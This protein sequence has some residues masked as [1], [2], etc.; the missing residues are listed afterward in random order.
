MR[1]TQNYWE[2][3]IGQISA[4]SFAK[5][6]NSLGPG[7]VYVLTVMGAGDIVSNSA[8]GA[9]YQYALI[10]ALGVTLI[11]R[12]IWVGASAKY[13]LVTGETLL[14]GYG[15]L[16][17]WLIWTVLAALFVFRHFYNLYLIVLLGTTWDLLFHLPTH[18][19]SAI[20]SV[21]FSVAGFVMM[22]WGG[23]P[24][25]E[26]FCKALVAAK[27][28]SL[29]IAAALSHPDPAG[30]LKGTFVPTIPGAT[31]FYSSILVLM[32]L[33]G[34]EAGSM[35]N[36]TYPYFMYEKGWR[37]VSYIRQQRFDL[38]FGVACI[39]V[40]GALL[41]IAAAGT[42]HPLGVKLE[43]PEQLVRIFSQSQG[44]VGLL[45]FALGL[46]GAA[47][48]TYVAAT[49][50]YALIMTDL[51]RSYIPRLRKKKVEGENKRAT[52]KN[53][54][55]Y[56]WSIAFWAFSPLYILFVHARPVWFV[57]MVSS[58]VVVVIPAL[59]LPLLRLTND[60]KLM[61]KHTNGWFTNMVL[62][63]LIV[64]SFYFTYQNI[65]SV[66]QQLRPTFH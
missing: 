16:G 56:R 64:V 33:I 18:W 42:I 45:I 59:A 10:W 40:M 57:L 22:S 51:C 61:G 44:L 28:I 1:L 30:I 5:R 32:A 43:G 36:L 21:F 37:D 46:W 17:N 6:L 27:G 49:T 65:L 53:D 11:F 25:L 4:S 24:I 52:A 23:Y 31:G 12:Y 13:V 8:A 15:R 29:I 39:F 9:D 38:G 47:F 48:S 34:T 35:T 50:G 55:I 26:Y 60:R 62:L 41:Q 20:W 63:M 66:W 14:Q 3:R 7:L 19:S 54:P 2:L 58:M